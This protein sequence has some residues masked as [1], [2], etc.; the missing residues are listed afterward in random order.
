MAKKK[1]NLITIIP[2]F[3]LI[4]TAIGVQ[5]SNIVKHSVIGLIVGVVIYF[6][7]TNRNKKLNSK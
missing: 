3:L 5:T 6:F 1:N 2:A 4:G 7:L